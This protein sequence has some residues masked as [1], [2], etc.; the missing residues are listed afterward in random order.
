M[1]GQF[2]PESV[3]ALLRGDKVLKVGKRPAKSNPAIA[4]LARGLNTIH[5][6]VE[7]WSKPWR[8]ELQKIDDAIQVLVEVLPKHLSSYRA[9]DI[10]VADFRTILAAAHRARHFHLPFAPGP[11]KERL[12]DIKKELQGIF[13]DALPNAPDEAG[14]RFIKA[15]LPIITGEKLTDPAVK[16]EILKKR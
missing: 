16:T 3:Y 4:R 9:D 2:T 11:P 8:K 5:H 10:R 14:Y 6:Q 15:V 7:F 1:S 13:R 12:R